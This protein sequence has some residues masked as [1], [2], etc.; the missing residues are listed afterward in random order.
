M[1]LNPNHPSIHPTQL[2]TTSIIN[3]TLWQHSSTSSSCL[4]LGAF[5]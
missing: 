1:P 5:Q 3:Y 2:M 4:W